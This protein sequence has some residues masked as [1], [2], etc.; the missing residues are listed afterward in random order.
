VTIND[1]AIEAASPTRFCAPF[2]RQRTLRRAV[3][4]SVEAKAFAGNGKRSPERRSDF[5]LDAPTDWH[6]VHALLARRAY[7]RNPTAEISPVPPRA[8][9][10]PGA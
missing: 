5:F 8:F 4:A 9:W 3:P 6:S 7:F 2:A 10:F 1:I